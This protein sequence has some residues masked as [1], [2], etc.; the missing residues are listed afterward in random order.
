MTRKKIDFFTESVNC[1]FM[2]EQNEKLKHWMKRH[3]L[4]AADAAPMFGISKQTLHNWVSAGVP[5][6]KIAH[7]ERVMTEYEKSSI[8]GIGPRIV[9]NPTTEQFRNWNQ[10]ALDNK[11]LIEEWSIHSLE[12]AAEKHFSKTHILKV[13]E[14]PTPYRTNGTSGNA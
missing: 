6:N 13:A 8:A 9:I 7:C 5:K 1:D 12:E 2:K 3:G 11:M 14:D 10:A 4:Q